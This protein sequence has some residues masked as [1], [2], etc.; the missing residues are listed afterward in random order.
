VPGLATFVAL[1]G[2]ALENG[3]FF[4]GAWTTATVGFLWLIVVA[5]LLD[6]RLELTRAEVAWL[7]LLA[8]IA[9]WTALSISWSLNARESAFEVR[10]DAVY[11]SAAGALLLLGTRRSIVHVV[12]AVWAAVSAV[13]LY[14]LARYLLAPSL[15][16]DQ[17]QVNLLFRPLGYANA[18]GIFAGLGAVLAVAFTVRAPTRPV[19][20]LAAASLAPLTAALW[21]TASRASALAVLVGLVVMLALDSRRLDLL[22]AMIVIAPLAAVLVWLCERADLATPARATGAE[23]RAHLLALWIVLAAIT[24]AWAPRP[25]EAV[26]RRLARVDRRRL[27]L[28]SA[29]AAGCVVL[30]AVLVGRGR[31]DAFFTTGYRP[32]YWHVAWKEASAHPVF[33]AGGGAFA[34]YWSRYGDPNLEGG[35]LDAHNLYLETLAELGVLGLLLLA[36]TLALPLLVALR[37]RSSDL[38]AP[39]VGAYV[40]FLAHA[41]VD[42]DWEMPAVTLAALACG[43]AVLLTERET[44]PVHKL[45]APARTVLLVVA[46]ALAVFVL[47]AELVPSLE[48][49]YP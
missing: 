33:G 36:A 15:E 6:V 11:V 8:A 45:S 30:G 17:F 31:I 41:A 7:G 19:R 23:G 12:S 26:S 39:A 40:A 28:A 43:A 29:V 49:P 13:V 38:V 3:G 22:G 1:V 35:A 47:A 18:L 14:A 16:S 42:W 5:L 4:P 48:R 20:A 21:L 25:G 46:L 24:L 44:A 9:V 32:A 34:D 37:H 10:R 2:T 27:G